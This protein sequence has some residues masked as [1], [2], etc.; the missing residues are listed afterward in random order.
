MSETIWAMTPQGRKA[1]GQIKEEAGIRVLEKTV[2]KSKHLHKVLNAWGVD[3]AVVDR[4]QPDVITVREREEGLTYR[5]D[6][7]TFRENAL[8]RDFGFGRQY[9]L[10]LAFW[11][12]EEGEQPALFPVPV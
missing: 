6:L 8:T 7:R 2:H 5:V 4:L 10:P 3:A 1:V 12:R 9:L 11:T